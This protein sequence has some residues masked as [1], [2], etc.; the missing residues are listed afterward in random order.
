MKKS[1]RAKR[2][3]RNHKRH[4]KSAGLNLTALMD[5]FTILVFFL[6]VNSSSDVQVLKNTDDITMPVSI[7]D[8]LPK[9]TLLVRV[10]DKQ[11][12][13]GGNVVADVDKVIGSEE[14]VIPGLDKELQYQAS[15][16]PQLTEEE[17]VLGRPIT[18]QGDRDLPYELLKK[19][20]ATCAQAEYRDISLAVSRLERSSNE[21]E[22]Q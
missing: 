22:G 17:K 18:I 20:M 4:G 14:D 19:I 16:R 9:E 2:M 21:Q 15:R 3:E 13:V 6:M 12:L 7:A 10:S 1:L 11:I 5:I 8:Q